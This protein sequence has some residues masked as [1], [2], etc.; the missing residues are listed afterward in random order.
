MGSTNK[1]DEIDR[2][3]AANNLKDYGLLKGNGENY[4]IH[5]SAQSIMSKQLFHTPRFRELC[6]QCYRNVY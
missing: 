4:R 2:Q 6:N 1:I 3:A 5:R